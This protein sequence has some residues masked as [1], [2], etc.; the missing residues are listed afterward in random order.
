MTVARLGGMLRAPLLLTVLG[1]LGLVI[2]G[3]DLLVAA[4][5]Y[6]VVLFAAIVALFEIARGVAARR[7]ALGEAPL[8]AFVALFGRNQRR[9]GG[10]IVHLGVTVI[11]IGV[12]GSTIFQTEVQHTLD[13]GETVAIQDYALRYEDFVRAQAVD[14]R[15]MH[16]ASLVV[17]RH[18]DEVARIRPRIDEYPQLPMSIAGAHSTLENDFYV[19]LIRGDRQRATFRI[20]INPLVNLVWWGGLLLILGTAI[21]AYPKVKRV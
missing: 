13:R 10:Y 11:G 21:A 2:V 17:L 18:G 14:G 20:Y 1:V 19:L 3:T 6:G 16:I 7:R 12:I 4:L 8:R 5:G 9:Y 15:H